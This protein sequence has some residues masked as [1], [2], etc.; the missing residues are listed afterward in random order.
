MRILSSYWLECTI[1]LILLSLVAFPNIPGLDAGS[2][3]NAILALTAIV[4]LWY[5]HETKR[6]RIEIAKQNLLQTRPIL[7]MELRNQKAFVRNQGRGPA[8][9]S[10][11]KN[12]SARLDLRGGAESAE[13]TY[14]FDLPIFLALDSEHE[15]VM[16]RKNANSKGTVSE[17][18]IFFEIGKTTHITIQYE[19]I[20]GTLY[21]T[22]MEIRSGITQKISIVKQVALA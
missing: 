7:T 9:N 4:V 10:Y 21:E 14:D 6:M 16:F 17:P 5:T 12:F 11:V 3:N 1:V 20:E 15:L 13:E 18:D 2:I 8:L 22:S 19:D